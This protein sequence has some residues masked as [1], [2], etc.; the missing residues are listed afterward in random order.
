MSR[1]SPVN[2][3]SPAARRRWSVT[4]RALA[5]ILGGYAFIWLLTAAL[6]LLLPR[7]FGMSPFDAVLAATM[8]SFLVWAVIAMAAFH[9]RS[10]R[11]P[12][13]WLL[14]GGL[15]CMCLLWLLTGRPLP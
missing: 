14:A 1:P 10:A 12:W 5:A 2:G 7:A 8:S 11:R 13:A 3:L 15:A 9:A 4:S 6:S